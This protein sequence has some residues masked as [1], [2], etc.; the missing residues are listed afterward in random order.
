MDNSQA[1]KG[2]IRL[3]EN[4]GS[5]DFES[6]YYRFPYFAP[7]QNPGGQDIACIGLL[8]NPNWTGNE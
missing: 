6:V 5:M 3:I 1:K 8:L 4:N 2:E 7:I